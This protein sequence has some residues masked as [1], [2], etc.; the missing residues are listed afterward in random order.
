M[1][2]MEKNTEQLNEEKLDKVSGGHGGHIDY[3]ICRYCGY[4]IKLEGWNSNFCPR[5]R[6]VIR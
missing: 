4:E 6:R 5:C 3:I 1:D 2:N